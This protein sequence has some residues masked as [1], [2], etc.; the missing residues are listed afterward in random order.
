MLAAY[1]DK[2]VSNANSNEG[3]RTWADM[4]GKMLELGHH[5]H[6]IQGKRQNHTRQQAQTREFGDPQTVARM[7][8]V[9]DA[10]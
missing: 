10:R 8:T 5:F 2:C 4:G 9:F 6:V 1:Y 3:E 7:L